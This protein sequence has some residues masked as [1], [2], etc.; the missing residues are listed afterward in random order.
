M[1]APPQRVVAEEL[2]R[3][4][5]AVM[6]L[7]AM[8]RGAAASEED[9]IAEDGEGEGEGEG[10]GGGSEATS[11]GEGDPSESTLRQSPQKGRKT[12]ASKRRKVG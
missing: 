7:G 12:R 8:G 3:A 1:V 11:V 5:D 10:E 2:L 9:T 6:Q 4:C